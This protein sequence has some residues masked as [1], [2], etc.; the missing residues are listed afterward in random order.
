[1]GGEWPRLP[2][3]E[4]C[5]LIVDCV[6]K[7]APVVQGPTAFKMIRTTNVRNGRINTSDCRYVEEDTFR[8]WT[9]RAELLE[10]DIVLTR[11]APMGEVGRVSG[12]ENIF[13]GQRLVQYRANPSVLDSRYLLYAFRSRE[14]RHQFFMHEGSGSVVSHIRVPDCRKFEISVPS[15]IEQ[16][17]IARILGALDDKIEL[18]RQTNETLEA[19]AQALFK[20]WFVDFDPVIDNALAAGNEIP[21]PLQARAAA[22]QAL[23]EARKQ[24]PEEIRREFPDG[25]EFRDE[26]GWVPRGWDLASVA[27]SMLVNPKTQLSKGALATYVDMKALPTA[28][29]TVSEWQKKPYAGGAKFVQG[30]VLLARITPCLQNGKTAIVDFL[31]DSEVGFGSTEF[32]VL[33][34]DKAISSSFIACLAREPNFR[35]HCMQSMVGSSGRQRVQNSCFRDYYLSLPREDLLHE[36][37]S[38]SSSLLGRTYALR[39]ESKSLASLRDTLLPKLLSGELTIPDAEKLVA[40]VL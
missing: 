33:R 19:M 22:R 11:E 13:L 16:K 14:L 36:F 2:V 31:A 29:Y 4:V 37:D 23:G 20:S 34:Q 26:M 5:D 15:L 40:D 27:D 32:I 21:E 25:F 8:K 6:N 10:G 28:G 7:T 17:Y 35:L 38:V 30:D 1:M 3:S 24:L 18:N 12:G 9:R 39:S